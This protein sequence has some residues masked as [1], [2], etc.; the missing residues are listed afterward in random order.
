ME[1]IKRYRLFSPAK[2]EWVHAF[3]IKGFFTRLVVAFIMVPSLLIF[4]K[5]YFQYLETRDGTVLNDWLLERLFPENFS[6]HIFGL[7]YLSVFIG[8]L[9]LFTKPFILLR[10][11]E[12]AFIVFSIR[13][14]T[15]YLVKLNPPAG[16]IPLTDPI[17]NYFGYGG[18]LITKDLFFS[19]HTA[20]ILILFLAVK[21][22]WLKM[23]FLIASIAIMAMLLWQHV[24]YSVDILG[25]L[26]FT[27]SGWK[28]TGRYLKY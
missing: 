13:I 9:Y 2:Q 8:F 25:A 5:Y 20:C 21:N 22:R 12:T 14:F 3:S 16:I 1:L 27:V 26:F 17:A 19:G 18:P 6:A 15:L 28:I 7:L 24:H 4:L 23:F 10:V 11:L